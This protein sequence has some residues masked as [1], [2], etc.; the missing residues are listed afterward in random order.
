M[1]RLPNTLQRYAT[2]SEYLPVIIIIIIP[3]DV[4]NKVVYR[5]IDTITNRIELNKGDFETNKNFGPMV[6]ACMRP[7]SK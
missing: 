1:A 3:I 4:T 6:G 7:T 2:V 5:T